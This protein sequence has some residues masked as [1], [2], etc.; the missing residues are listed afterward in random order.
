MIPIARGWIALTEEKMELQK[1]EFVRLRLLD[2]HSLVTGRNSRCIPV[3][4]CIRV[5]RRRKGMAR[6]R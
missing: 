5:Y 4:E 6:H 2:V 1:P 3:E